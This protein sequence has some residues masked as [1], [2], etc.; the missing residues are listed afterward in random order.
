MA[1]GHN[2]MRQRIIALV[3][4]AAGAAL[5]AMGYHRGE[6]RVLFEKAVSICLECIGLG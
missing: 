3:V 1:R 4:M 6:V 5:M 2:P